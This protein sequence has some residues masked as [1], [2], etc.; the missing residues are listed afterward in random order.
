MTP[1]R[2]RELFK[3][4]LGIEDIADRFGRGVE[5]IRHW[6]KGGGDK[7]RRIHPT[8]PGRFA[9]DRDFESLKTLVPIDDRPIGAR[10]MG[11]PLPGRSALDRKNNTA[12]G[13]W[14]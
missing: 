13:I 2:A 11:D 5:T 10:L 6:I 1:E 9:A 3:S 8:N 4:G 14:R 12:K 7:N